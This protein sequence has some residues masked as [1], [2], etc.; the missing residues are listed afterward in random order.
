MV[1][2]FEEVGAAPFAAAPQVEE[3]AEHSH[4]IERRMTSVSMA[5]T[6]AAVFDDLHVS[7]EEWVSAM[8]SRIY[9]IEQVI[10]PAASPED[11]AQMPYGSALPSPTAAAA[12]TPRG[13][14][15]I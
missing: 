15:A 7:L 14:G 13:A 6:M 5:T 11:P 8:E 10:W 4:E 1:Q 12:V 9:N 2:Q 3:D